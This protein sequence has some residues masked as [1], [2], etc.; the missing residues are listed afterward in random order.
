VKK[1]GKE[2]EENSVNQACQSRWKGNEKEKET[3]KTLIKPP[4]KYNRE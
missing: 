3:K 2:K 1:K 4:K